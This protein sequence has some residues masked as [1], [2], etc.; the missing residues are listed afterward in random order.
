MTGCG[1]SPGAR[2]RQ[3]V[4]HGPFVV[5]HR[6]DLG[7]GACRLTRHRGAV[8]TEFT[9]LGYSERSEIGLPC[10]VVHLRD[11]SDGRE[12]VVDTGLAGPGLP[13]S[14][15]IVH[16]PIRRTDPAGTRC[17]LVAVGG[18]GG[19]TTPGRCPAPG[20]PFR[21]P[22]EV[23]ATIRFLMPQGMARIDRGE[24]ARARTSRRSR[25][26]PARRSTR[27]KP[28]LRGLHQRPLATG[29]H[30]ARQRRL[31][32][33]GRRVVARAPAGRAGPWRGRRPR[34]SRPPCGRW[35]R[36][37]PAG[38]R[39]GRRGR[40]GPPCRGRSTPAGARGSRVRVPQSCAIPFWAATESGS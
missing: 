2:V 25:A 38:R 7:L 17:G 21:Q 10:H 6:H 26:G 40:A 3:T 1:P 4:P 16:P 19:P 37:A 8:E 11:E 29:A 23:I 12:Y 36:G 22:P 32:R 13:P 18:A 20:L 28:A 14:A 33:E 30:R 15:F 35:S 31:R 5:Q 39:A 24:D 9:L 27:P 34:R